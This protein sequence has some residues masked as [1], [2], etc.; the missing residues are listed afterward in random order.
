MH[1]SRNASQRMQMSTDVEI[2]IVHT[3]QQNAH[4]R[5]V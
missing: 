5:M 4:A 1:V 3:R 2:K